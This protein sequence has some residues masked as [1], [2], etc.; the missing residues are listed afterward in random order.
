MFDVFNAH[1]PDLKHWTFVD[2]VTFV[3][4]HFNDP[5]ILSA[6]LRDLLLQSISVMVQYK[7]YLTAF[8]SNEA[9]TQGLPK[10]LLSAF[11][12]RSWIPVTNIIL[13]LSKRS[14]ISPRS[15][16]SSSS[17]SVVFQVKWKILCTLWLL[18]LGNACGHNNYMFP[19][20]DIEF[21][22]GSLCEWWRVVLSFPKS[23]I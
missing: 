22:A 17:S 7:E 23:L 15:G 14:H 12:N 9:A 1:D 16:E 18:S 19:Q 13:R 20:F 10:A 6:D 2:Q 21:A 3:V 8:E 5:R 11:D 4:T